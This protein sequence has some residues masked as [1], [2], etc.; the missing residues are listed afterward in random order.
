MFMFKKVNPRDIAGELCQIV[1]DVFVQNG[2]AQRHSWGMAEE[3]EES[4]S[5]CQTVS[6]IHVQNGEPQ[7]YSLGM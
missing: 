6:N 7:R 5:L 1:S 2:E 3:E 4:Q